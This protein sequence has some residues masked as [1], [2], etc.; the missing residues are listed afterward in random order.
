VIRDYEFE[1][2]RAVTGGA[3]L[4]DVKEVDKALGPL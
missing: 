3:L 2:E 4:L 1:P